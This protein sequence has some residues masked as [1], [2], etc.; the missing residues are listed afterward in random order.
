MGKR[1]NN[2]MFTAER[3]ALLLLAIV[4]IVWA[5][6][7]WIGKQSS[8]TTLPITSIPIDSVKG[9]VPSDSSKR[10]MS[11]DSVAI[12]KSD[13]IRK[14]KHSLKKRDKRKK[15]TK[16]KKKTLESKGQRDHLREPITQD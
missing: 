10:N 11:P 6:L 7:V 15:E 8:E 5:C 2:K 4:V 13:T 12:L 16:K 3:V 14:S 1:G 9:T